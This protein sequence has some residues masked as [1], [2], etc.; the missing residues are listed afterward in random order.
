[1]TD[2]VD[3]TGLSQ[4][5]GD[6]D[7]AA[8]WAA[9]DQ[10]VRD[11]LARWQ[12]QE[13][14]KSDGF[15]LVFEQVD[16]ALQF[17]RACHE[18]LSKLSHPVPMR[19]GIHCGP[20][21]AR[22]NSDEAVARGAKPVELDG[23]TK[24]IVA[25]VMNL[26]AGGQT[27]LTSFAR[28][29]LAD[30]DPA[31]FGLG[32]W[33]LQG[34]DEPVE[35]FEDVAPG[36]SPQG[37]V[38]L[39]KA[40]QVCWSDGLWVPA[41]SV[42]H[43]LP[44]E[45]DG[46]IGRSEFLREIDRRWGGGS[47]LVSVVGP[48][49]AGKTRLALRHG[50]LVLGAYPGGVWFCDLSHAHGPDGFASSVAQGL[51]MQLGPGDP[52]LQLGEALASRGKVLVI[53]DNVE[54][55]ISHASECIGRWMGTATDAHFLVTSREI[56]NLPGEQVT[57][58]A[59]MAT[60]EAAALFVQRASEA[61]QG[62]QLAEG[63]RAS[64]D[65]L[66]VLLDGL[67]LAIEMAAART[68][69]MSPSLLLARM[70]KRFSLLAFP[71]G[72]RPSRHA[73][74]RATLD[75][76]WELL[77]GT[78]RCAL[79]QLSVFEG[80]FDLVSFEGVLTFPSGAQTCWPADVLQSLVEQSM[81]RQVGPGRFDLLNSV[82]EYAAEKLRD[83]AHD[84]PGISIRAED[85]ERRHFEFF[86]ALMER[87]A[88][89]QHCIELNNLKVASLR[90]AAAGDGVCAVS[91]LALAWS[92]L[93]L[94]GPF[95]HG[96]ALADAVAKCRS[97]SPVDRARL[98]AQRGGVLIA[99]GRSSE[100]LGELSGG[101]TCAAEAGHDGSTARLL[102]LM[103][104]QLLLDGR[105]DDARTHL[106]QSLALAVR[107]DDRR[108]Q[109]LA[110]TELGALAQATAR[111]PEARQHFSAALA[112][113]QALDDERMEGGLLGNLGLLAHSEGCLDD[114][115]PLYEQ[116]LDKAQSVG[117]RRWGGNTHCNLGLLHHEQGRHAQAVEQFEAALAMARALGQRGL[118]AAVL[119]NLALTLEAV[120][121]WSTALAHAQRAVDLAA[122]LGQPRAEG[123]YRGYLAR[124]L[125][126]A[127]QF[128]QADTCWRQGA[129]LLSAV[130]DP[131][132][133]GVLLCC[134]VEAQTMAGQARNAARQLS[135][136][137][138]IA[139]RSGAGA[140][141]ELGQAITRARSM[142]LGPPAFSRDSRPEGP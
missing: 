58:L 86:A 119:C 37:L 71:T 57:M 108:G 94:R 99:L 114:A 9:H 73:T 24:S 14:D 5:L 121:R 33:R 133:L 50:W 100:A 85:A 77:S 76:S 42:P 102:C 63:D 64:V 78:E 60:D 141:T 125:A 87:Q 122:A 88:V 52:G 117:D 17:V 139:R 110:L 25:R 106:D 30:R 127:G 29:A 107:A 72:G 109:C 43:S 38:D 124:L 22:R 82:R 126:R 21:L 142:V 113:A 115:R 112:L 69:V 123:Q 116:A 55:V 104:Q 81:V 84:L 27:L 44:I 62:F 13:I 74:L 75:W 89:A 16:P 132:S 34:V 53:L 46:F 68:R 93:K 26:A 11:L 134:A 1:M 31:F 91:N 54:Q 23:L 7:A 96:L 131:L 40:Y 2:A 136:A 120:G 65:D 92:A 45:R 118:E 18:A 59:S 51:A 61:Q 20:V 105:V 111:W 41:R 6:M 4:R 67:P 128:D 49:G 28:D 8:H 70:N 39:P 80:G 32:S 12:G 83:P 97:L 56:L 95:S 140:N 135:R 101:L 3:S 35:L 15:L 98:A 79:A 19:A 137:Q 10:A 36:K 90:A 138:A 129:K 48:G 66:M 130:N 103:G 47:R